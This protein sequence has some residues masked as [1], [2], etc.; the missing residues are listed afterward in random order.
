[1]YQEEPV[2]SEFLAAGDEINLALLEIDSR[3]FATAGDRNLAQRAVFADVMAKRGLRDRREAVLC[4][5]ISALVANRPIMTS[6]F[7]FVEL[8][9]LCMLR[10]APSLVDRF[11]AVKRDNPAFGLGEIMAVAIE[12]RERHQWGHYWQE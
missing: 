5:E 2:L 3:E 7:D 9:A 12:A 6:L 8:K 11:I 4:H 10:V 1:M